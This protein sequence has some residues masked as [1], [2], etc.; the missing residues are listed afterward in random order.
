MSKD[1]VQVGPLFRGR[2][3]GAIHCAIAAY[4][5]YAALAFAVGIFATTFL[6]ARS[7][8]QRS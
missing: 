5:L 4:S 1:I 2:T 8:C 7:A 3:N 6:S